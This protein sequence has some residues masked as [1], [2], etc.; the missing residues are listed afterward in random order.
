MNVH[1]STPMYREEQGHL[2]FGLLQATGAPNRDLRALQE[3]RS[4]ADAIDFITS[5][6]SLRKGASRNRSAHRPSPL[7]ASSGGS[8]S[9]QRCTQLQHCPSSSLVGYA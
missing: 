9:T 1:V 5:L 6:F 3:L 8:R 2:R 7:R 4:F